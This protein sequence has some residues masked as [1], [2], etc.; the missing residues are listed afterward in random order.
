MLAKHSAKFILY[1]FSGST[2]AIVD[3]GLYAIL[4]QWG[5]WY[6]AASLMSG[7]LAFFTAFLLHKYIVY[8]KR[9]TFIKHLLRYFVIDM[10]NLIV[11]TFF[12]YIFVHFLFIDPFFAKIL[13]ITP[14]VLWNFFIYKFVVYT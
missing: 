1:I 7:V 14:V 12:L 5:V 4:L 13:A 8:Q 10:C 9:S 11:I 3:I 6:I 2:A